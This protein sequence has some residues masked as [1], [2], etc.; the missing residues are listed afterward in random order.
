[1]VERTNVSDNGGVNEFVAFSL[2]S[3][4]VPVE[5]EVLLFDIFDLIGNVGGYLGLFLGAS[6]LSMYDSLIIGWGGRALHR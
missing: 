2:T 3:G 6:I 4:S 1:M 5:E